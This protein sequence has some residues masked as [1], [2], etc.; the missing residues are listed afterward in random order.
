MLWEPDWNLNIC[1]DF[2]FTLPAGSK[3]RREGTLIAPWEHDSLAKDYLLKDYLLNKEKIGILQATSS[4]QKK[5]I[6]PT[7]LSGKASI[8]LTSRYTAEKH[9]PFYLDVSAQLSS[10]FSCDN[11]M[12]MI[13][14]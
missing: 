10:T 4:N 6:N 2:F 14:K 7:G 11:P 3:Q 8:Y 13:H 12:L 5:H 9:E 1:I